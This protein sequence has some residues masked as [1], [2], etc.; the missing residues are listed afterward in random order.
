[1]DRARQSMSRKG[2]LRVACGP[3]GGGRFL[4]MDRFISPSVLPCGNPPPSSEG[5][6]SIG[7]LYY[8]I[9]RFVQNDTTL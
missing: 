2:K 7:T 5:G 4:Q 3:S 9:L 8:K 6:S 1:M